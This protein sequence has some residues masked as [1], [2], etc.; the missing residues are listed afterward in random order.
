MDCW[1]WFDGNDNTLRSHEFGGEKTV[2][3]DIRA[4][5]DESVAR[6]QR[7]P[8]PSAYTRFPHSKVIKVSLDQVFG[9]SRDPI[10]EGQAALEDVRV[11]MEVS[12]QPRLTDRE[13]RISYPGASAW[14]QRLAEP[15][16]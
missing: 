2:V 14:N 13:R 15:R 8:N 16:S 7:F 5:I 12:P 1:R 4:N 11:P 3:T 10:A 9:A 6:S